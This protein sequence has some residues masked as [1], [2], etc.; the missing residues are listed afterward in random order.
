MNR[1]LSTPSFDTAIADAV[2]LPSRECS[3]RW[4]AH[5]NEHRRATVFGL[6]K[7][8]LEGADDIL[9]VNGE[10][11]VKASAGKVSVWG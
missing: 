10:W 8:L 4:N 1:T 7:N 2:K 3:S 6:G 9:K 11:E 5:L